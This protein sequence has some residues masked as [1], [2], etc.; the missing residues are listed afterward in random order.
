[1]SDR[2][3]TGTIKVFLQ[4][5]MVNPWP[6]R[7]V[8]FALAS[9]FIYGGV[10]KLFNPRAFAA[11][12]SAYDLVPEALLPVVAIGLPIIETIA[13]VAL[14]FGLL[15]GHHLISVLLALFV[16]VLGYGVLG[17]MNVDCGCFGAEE[18]NKQAGLRIAFYR[19]LI[20]LGIV[21]PYLYISR[22]MRLRR[23]KEK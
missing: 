19:D 16:F 10:I 14:L 20:L 23:V 22:W 5:V 4:E 6:G 11:T 13:G 17:D 12:I 18:L 21:M 15:W 9:V 7:V 2:D 8:R 1:M 3:R